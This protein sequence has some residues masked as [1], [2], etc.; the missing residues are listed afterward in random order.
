MTN[1]EKSLIAGRI[2]ALASEDGRSDIEKLALIAAAAEL[3]GRHDEAT[4]HCPAQAQMEE[5]G[6]ELLPG[7]FLEKHM[8]TGE[9]GVANSNAGKFR[10]NDAQPQN[11]MDEDVRV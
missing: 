2:F 5:E 8:G 7:D 10:R 3:V 9:Q 4:K 1:N 6:F 11:S